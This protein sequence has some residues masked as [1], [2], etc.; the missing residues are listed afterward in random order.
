MQASPLKLQFSGEDLSPPKDPEFDVSKQ[1]NRLCSKSKQQYLDWTSQG[2][3]VQTARPIDAS[4]SHDCG[5]QS[6][7]PSKSLAKNANQ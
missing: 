5:I 3:S 6:Q 2:N 7:S 1:P 4:N